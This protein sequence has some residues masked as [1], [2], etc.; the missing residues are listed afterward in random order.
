[1]KRTLTIHIY[2]PAR[3]AYDV[4][5]HYDTSNLHTTNTSR[6]GRSSTSNNLYQ[7]SSN[8][9]LSG[10]VIKDL[11]LSNHFPSVLRCIIHGVATSGY[12]ACITFGKTLEW[13][14]DTAHAFVK[15]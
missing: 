6:F 3:S 7:L 1:M 2:F 13:V 4:D 10:T 14:L 15:N 11:E 8:D 5:G 12:F 9:G